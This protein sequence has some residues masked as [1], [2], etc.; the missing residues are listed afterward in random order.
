MDNNVTL[1][2][3]QQNS[4]FDAISC[5]DWFTILDI[6]KD[7]YIFLGYHA[8]S[9]P[10]GIITAHIITIEQKREKCCPKC[11]KDIYKHEVVTRTL[12]HISIG[13]I[14]VIIVVKFYRYKCT[15]CDKTFTPVVH[16]QNG[17][18]RITKGLAHH[19]AQSYIENKGLTIKNTALAQGVSMY[20]VD[21]VIFGNCKTNFHE[22]S[23]SDTDLESDVCNYKRPSEMITHIM[24][25]EIATHNRNYVT[26]FYNAKNHDLLF[27]VKKNNKSAIQ[28]FIKWAGITLSPNVYIACDMNAPF[29]SAF[30]EA[31]PDCTITFDRFHHMSNI[32]D[33]LK[34]VYMKL[35]KDLPDD[36][37]V[38]PLFFEKDKPALRLLFLR[39]SELKN[40]SDIKTLK[41]ILKSSDF[42]KSIYEFY[43]GVIALYDQAKQNKDEADFHTNLLALC[44]KPLEVE[45][46]S[47]TFAKYKK[48][49]QLFSKCGCEVLH[50]CCECRL[51]ASKE[52][53]IETDSEDHSKDS[54]KGKARYSVISKLVRRIVSKG[55]HIASFAK[56]QL[57]TGPIEGL[58]N[59][60]KVLK[61]ARYGIKNLSK[62]M[63]LLKLSNQRP[64]VASVKTKLA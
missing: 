12:R 57:T 14:P 31:L 37:P 53:S 43:T 23:T 32:V 42:I 19:I 44:K 38:K 9:T 50:Q 17:R 48:N 29:L 20:Y 49:F 45:A 21:S 34:I 33:D 26:L 62:F 2:A 30:K 22:D 3:S 39:E 52:N 51:D 41:T 64:Y 1:H 40:K 36:S 63:D 28:S 47:S 5:N 54:K 61:R 24:V 18:Q 46:L 56:T 25:D 60:L 11:N 15:V 7:D 8:N 55:P 27:W 13:N 10:E 58:N 4:G 59:K 6:P 16:I 35:A